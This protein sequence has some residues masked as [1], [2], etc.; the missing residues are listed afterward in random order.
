MANDIY[1]LQFWMRAT[2]GEI[3]L[4]GVP[5]WSV[6]RDLGQ[7]DQTIPLNPYVTAR[8][9]LELVID[10]EGSPS[11]CRRPR[12]TKPKPEAA[13]VVRVIRCASGQ[14]VIPADDTGTVVAKLV[15][16]AE[17]DPSDQYPRVLSTEFDA[18]G[19]FG[20]WAWQSAPKLTL[21]DATRQEAW[22]VL[23]NVRSA[24]RTGDAKELF[25]LTELCVREVGRAFGEAREAESL[26]AIEGWIAQWAAE[27][28]R[29][30]PIDT[31]A[32]DFRLVADD[33]ILIP[34]NRDW[35]HPVQ[36]RQAVTDQDNVAA[37]D[38]TLSYPVMLARV[39]SGL[40]IVRYGN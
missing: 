8:N 24:I 35:T 5:V 1:F 3:S 6:P 4:N 38:F 32:F 14:P 10:I 37:G 18:A 16:V 27:P 31:K 25:R 7:T 29:V 40:A 21:D 13:V 28:E 30:L 12:E 2:S 17:K 11:E 9:K 15:W 19:G 20:S 39:G 36:M 34:I 22:T 23:E 26:A 33:K